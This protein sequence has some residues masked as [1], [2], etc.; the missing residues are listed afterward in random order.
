MFHPTVIHAAN[1]AR[2]TERQRQARLHRQLTAARSAR[3]TR[4]LLRR[5]AVLRPRRRLVVGRRSATV[6]APT[7]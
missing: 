3:S 1:A 7:P 5:A 6:P 4:R 2:I